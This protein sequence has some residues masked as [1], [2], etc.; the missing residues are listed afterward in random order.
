MAGG[1]P[2]DPGHPGSKPAAPNSRDDGFGPAQRGGLGGR[3][4]GNPTPETPADSARPADGFGP[5]HRGGLGGS[6]GGHAPLRQPVPVPPRRLRRRLIVTLIAAP[7]VLIV[8]AGA[9][10]ALLLLTTSGRINRIEVAGL[11]PAAPAMNVLLVGTDSRDGLTAEE[12]QALGTEAVGGNRTDTILLLSISGGRAAMLSFPRDLWLEQCNGQRGRIN[13]AHATGGPS[14]LVDTVTR[15]TGI[16]LTHYAEINFIGFLRM[17]DAVGGVS[18]YLPE[19]MVDRFAGVDLP[20]GC[21]TLDGRK[22]LGFVRARHI[23]SDLGRVQRQQRFL[24]ELAAEIAQPSTLLNV[25]RLFRTAHAGARS[26]TANNELGTMDL[27][28]LA[29]GGRGMAGGGIASY[30]V[31]VQSARKGGAAVLVIDTAPA[32]DIFAAFASGR[33]LTPVEATAAP[34]PPPATSADST[35][36]A[37]LPTATC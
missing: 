1:R 14:C 23:D 37:P 7:L 27:L 21:V 9:V 16:P 29:R 22:A 28:R 34:A 20:A 13:T 3:L 5:V 31:P 15:A 4:G 8:L 17:V 24:A 26:L 32:A 35:A 36:P 12:L 6:P 11:A 10:G 33:V 25:P 18:L 19:P 2:L 30:T